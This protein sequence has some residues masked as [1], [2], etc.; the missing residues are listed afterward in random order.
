VV[1]GRYPP[2]TG[3][4]RFY[5]ADLLG[6]MRAVVEGATVVESYDFELWGC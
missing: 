6:S 2:S 1:V 3:S 5:H 4:K